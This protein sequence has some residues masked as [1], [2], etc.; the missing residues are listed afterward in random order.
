MDTGAKSSH[1]ESV[2][3]AYPYRIIAVLLGIVGFFLG[4]RP[5]LYP[6][7]YL[8]T[9]QVAYAGLGLLVL[10]VLL[11]FKKGRFSKEF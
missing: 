1:R 10:A 6:V 3:V 8:T 5:E 2:M 9:A 11:F 7:P 4:T